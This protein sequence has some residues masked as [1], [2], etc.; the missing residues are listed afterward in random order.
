VLRET[1]DLGRQP[2]ALWQ[3]RAAGSSG[4]ALTE[5]VGPL[6]FAGEHTAGEW[7]SLMEGA[8]RSGLRAA[9]Q[10]LRAPS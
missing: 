4:E 7:A 9:E 10:V 1:T 5:P 8:L 3:A 6:V 2:P